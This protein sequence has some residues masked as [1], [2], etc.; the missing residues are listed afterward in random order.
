MEA[1]RGDDAGEL[2]VG[3][4][5]LS[6]LDVIALSASLSPPEQALDVGEA[7][8]HVSGPAV[9]ALAGLGVVSIR[10]VARSSHRHYSNRL[11]KLL[12]QGSSESV[13]PGQAA[14]GD[15]DAT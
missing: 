11:R 5:A 15:G 7:K 10:A 12:R 6:F 8:L 9:I 3:A 4:A 1:E 13:P 2:R 14:G